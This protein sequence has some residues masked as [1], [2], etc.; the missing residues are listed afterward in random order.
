MKAKGIGLALRAERVRRGM[1]QLDLAL[2]SGVSLG[3]VSLAERS[4]RISKS[5]AAR[6]AAALGIGPATLKHSSHNTNARA[7]NAGAV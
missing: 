7:V 3:T 1:S 2:K 6:F 4:G 5:V